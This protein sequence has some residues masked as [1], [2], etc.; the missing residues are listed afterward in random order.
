M[1]DITMCTGGRCIVKETCK[2]F[3]D[4]ADDVAQ[5]YFVVPPGNDEH[6][7][8]YWPVKKKPDNG[9]V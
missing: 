6:C 4:Q 3:L 7:E 9:V 2:R 5:S 8:E 1:P